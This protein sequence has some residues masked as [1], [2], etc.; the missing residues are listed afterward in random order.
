MEFP[1]AC[2]PTKGDEDAETAAATGRLRVCEKTESTDSLTVAAR[3]EC[4]RVA[5][6]RE[7]VP[8]QSIVDRVFNGVTMRLRPTNGDEDA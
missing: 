7:P 2:W 4:Y 5:T 8:C 6:V 3:K 1:W